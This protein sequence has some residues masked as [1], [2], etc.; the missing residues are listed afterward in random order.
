[1]VLS[2]ALSVPAALRT[3]KACSLSPRN[4]RSPHSPLKPHTCLFHVSDGLFQPCLAAVCST[5]KFSSARFP[6]H[7]TTCSGHVGASSFPAVHCRVLTENPGFASTSHL[8]LHSLHCSCSLGTHCVFRPGS[9]LS[10]LGSLPPLSVLY[11]SSSFLPGPSYLSPGNL[12][13]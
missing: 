8:C 6:S 1:M 7:V 5:T 3:K 2:V 12:C 11:P 9:Q 10:S 13:N 4:P